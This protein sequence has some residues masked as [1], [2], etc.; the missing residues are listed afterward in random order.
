MEVTDPTSQHRISSLKEV[1]PE[2]NE[3]MFVM[4]DTSQQLI[5]PNTVSATLVV[6]GSVKRLTAF[7]KSLSEAKVNP[8]TQQPDVGCAVVESAG[9]EVGSSNGAEVGISRGDVVGTSIGDEVGTSF[10]MEV[11]PSNGMD[12]GLSIG[13]EVGLSIGDDVGSMFGEK[14]GSNTGTQFAQTLAALGSAWFTQ[15]LDTNM[16]CVIAF[17]IIFECQLQRSRLKKEPEN[18]SWKSPT[19]DTSH[20]STA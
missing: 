8:E 6:A 15:E 3:S 14:V 10:G 5:G 19:F 20:T 1:L 2:N 4:A 12:V 18:V 13:D 16:S 11:G 9:D 7:C 17:A